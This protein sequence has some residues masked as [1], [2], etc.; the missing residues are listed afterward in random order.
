MK[1]KLVLLVFLGFAAVGEAQVQVLPPGFTLFGKT[2][3]DFLVEYDQALIPL[4]TNEDFSFPKAVPSTTGPVYFLHRP[5]FG[6]PVP[7]I[8]QTY[9]IPDNVYVYFAV[10]YYS[11][12]NIGNDVPWTVGE[13]KDALK[14]TLDAVTELHAIIDGVA[15]TNLFAYRA[16][17]PVFSIFFPSSD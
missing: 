8:T 7:S 13:L 10:L 6:V 17:S 15:V 3:A 14:A 9:F 16:E 2:S 4:S 12:D 1:T 11:F 5:N